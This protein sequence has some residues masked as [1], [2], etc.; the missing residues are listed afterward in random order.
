MLTDL[1]E[2]EN[3]KCSWYLPKGNGETLP[4]KDELPIEEVIMVTQ[5]EGPLKPT[6]ESPE[7]FTDLIERELKLEYKGETR[8]VIHYHLT[9]W[10]DFEAAPEG[11]LAKL[12]GLVWKKHYSRGEHIISHCSAGIGRSGT[13]L[14]IL[15]TFSKLNQMPVLTGDLVFNVVKQ[16]RSLENGREGMVQN[17][18]QYGLIFKTLA[19][20]NPLCAQWLC[21]QDSL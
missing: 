10:R 8:T 20:L 13:F 15:E 4:A 1:V 12:V 2:N 18:K 14:A 19:I 17:I 16:L 21:T 11:L 3:I 5:V 6:E 7:G 9:G